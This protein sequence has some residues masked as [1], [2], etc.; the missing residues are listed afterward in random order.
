MPRKSTT[1]TIDYIRK[2]YAK[3]DDLLAG[4]IARL[5][6]IDMEIQIGAEEG[7]LLQMFISLH[8]V[9]TV[10]EVGTLGG[11]STIWMARALP[12]GGHI[13]TLNKDQLHIEI[14]RDAFARSG[15]QERI[16][17][18]EGD[19]HDALPTLNAKGPFD[20]IFIDADKISYN[21]YLDWAEENI[22]PLGLI[23]ADNTLLFG[24]IADKEPPADMAPSTWHSMQL[25]NE[26][27]ADS[28]KY[29]SVLIP[30]QEGLTV[31]VKLF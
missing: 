25:F 23:I 2:L 8:N 7:K 22:R 31:A 27:L 9:K 3:Q 24:S 10:V 4:I 11:Y 6:E 28:S 18:L 19:A 26:R 13:Y 17:M 16:T 15:L 29:F 14:A 12:E 20:M 5:A 30:T 1:P 21:D